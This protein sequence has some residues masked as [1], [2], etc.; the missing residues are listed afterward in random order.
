[1]FNID[2]SGVV[3][4]K[5]MGKIFSK[6]VG[7]LHRYL[8]CTMLKAKIKI[9]RATVMALVNAAGQMFCSVMVHS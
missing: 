5:M 3:H 4:R 1:M 2:E 9:K 6:A 7:Y 8:V